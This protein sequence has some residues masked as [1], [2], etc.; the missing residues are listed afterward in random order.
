MQTSVHYS[1]NILFEAVAHFL[2]ILASKFHGPRDK[3]KLK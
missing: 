2:L 3:E 1:D